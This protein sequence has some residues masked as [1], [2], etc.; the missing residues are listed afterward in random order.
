MDTSDLNTVTKSDSKTTEDRED[1]MRAASRAGR[2]GKFQHQRRAPHG[3]PKPDLHAACS[4]CCAYSTV[5]SRPDMEA[6]KDQCIIAGLSRPEF[7]LGSVN[8]FKPVPLVSKMSLGPILMGTM[9]NVLL[10]GVMIVQCFVYFERYKRDR[11]MIKSIVGL[12]L[13]LDGLSSAFAMAMTYNYLVTNFANPPAIAVTNIGIDP[14]PLLTGVTA[15]V[16]QWF[17][18]WR[19]LVLTRSKLLALVIA[20]LSMSLTYPIRVP[21]CATSVAGIGTMIGGIIVKEFAKLDQVKQISLVWLLGS[22]VTDAI[23][24]V[25]LVACLSKKTGFSSTDNLTSK[26][27]R[28]KCI[29]ILHLRY[30]NSIGHLVTVQTGLATTTFALGTVI[31]FLV[32]SSTLHLAFGLPLS[33]LYTNSLLSSLNARGNWSE[34][35]LGTSGNGKTAIK[36]IG[37]TLAYNVPSVSVTVE[38]SSESDAFAAKYGAGRADIESHEMRL[39]GKW[40]QA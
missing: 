16:V 15:L 20:V 26:L 29:P 11:L 1:L 8:Q 6:A 18:A 40:G 19:I 32:S 17:F 31:A 4:Y 21:L 33:K 30:T 2:S 13:F 27:I 22:V 7:G 39:Y 36:T 23:I 34:E 10:L 35:G 12:L 28:S 9:M 37:S 3:L 5:D 38:R 14:Y 24:T 25:S